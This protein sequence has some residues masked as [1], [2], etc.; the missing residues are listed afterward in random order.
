MQ[1]DKLEKLSCLKIEDSQKDGL[2]KSLEGVFSMMHSLEQLSLM[3]LEHKDSDLAT[4]LAPARVQKDGLIK[5]S[6]DC[7]GIHLQEGYFLAPKA[8]KK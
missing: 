5:K 4:Q 2:V 8:I 1:L 6:E 3:P 7:A